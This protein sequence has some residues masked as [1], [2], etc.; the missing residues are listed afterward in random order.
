[1]RATRGESPLLASRGRGPQDG[2]K[3]ECVGDLYAHQGDSG[4]DGQGTHG[5][6]HYIMGKGVGADR[7]QKRARLQKKWGGGN[8]GCRMRGGLVIPCGSGH[9]QRL[10]S[11]MPPP[12][13]TEP[14][15]YRCGVVLRVA[16]GRI[17][18]VG[19]GSQRE[20]VNASK[21]DEGH[22]GQAARGRDPFVS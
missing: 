19:H 7:L 22:L 15:W 20:A 9:F 13:A 14:W 18:A 4:D 16:D 12:G 2:S 17:G 3:D 5:V 11:R 10:R 21:P 1:M 8:C 6:H